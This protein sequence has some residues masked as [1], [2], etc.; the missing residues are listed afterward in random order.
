MSVVRML[1]VAISLIGSRLKLPT[2]A[3]VGWFGP[4][5][6]A[7]ILFGLFILEEAE[8]AVADELFTVV[9]WTVLASI[10]LHGVTALWLSERYGTWFAGHGRDSMQEAMPVEEMPTR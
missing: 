1:P 6:L 3:F 8:L 5:G 9:I 7:S 4:R 10:A 2:V